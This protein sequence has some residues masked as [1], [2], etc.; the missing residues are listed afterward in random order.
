M[1]SSPASW[2]ETATIKTSSSSSDTESSSD[3]SWN[4]PTIEDF[5]RDISNS[6][7]KLVQI[8]AAI[9]KSSTQNRSIRADAY[10]EWEDGPAGK[11]SKSKGFE[12]FVGILLE[13]RY[14]DLHDNVRNR[15]RIALS[16]CNRRI[17]YQRRHQSRIRYDSTRDTL[18]AA[19]PSTAI[20][21]PAAAPSQLSALGMDIRPVSS[22]QADHLGIA[23]AAPSQRGT[24]VSASTLSPNFS[25]FD[26]ESKSSVSS[27]SSFSRLAANPYNDLPPPPPLKG[28]ERY[29]QCPY[30]CIQLPRKRTGKRAWAYVNPGLLLI[31]AS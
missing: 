13:Y 26:H 1:A 31:L 9:K 12:D 2:G 8:S 7:D 21:A 23:P 19:H 6:V 5:L 25:P 30:C 22:H 27:G 10:E 3:E 15:L 4:V 28:N 29:F 24:N 14:R 16:R 11:I 20:T 18:E 17:A